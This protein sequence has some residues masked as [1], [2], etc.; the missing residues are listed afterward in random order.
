MPFLPFAINAGIFFA[1]GFAFAFILFYFFFDNGCVST[2]VDAML[3]GE[4]A[5]P[6]ADFNA[7]PLFF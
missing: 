2:F 4:N 3:L 6:N 7:L 5:E 1:A